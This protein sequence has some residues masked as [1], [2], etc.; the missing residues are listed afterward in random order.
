VKNLKYYKDLTAV[1]QS[2]FIN[3]MQLPSECFISHLK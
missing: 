2:R 1:E 3:E